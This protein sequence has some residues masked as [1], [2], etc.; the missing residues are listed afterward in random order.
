MTTLKN[1]YIGELRTEAVHAR[2]GNKIITDA[3]VD[4][5]GKGEAFSPT[6]LL[7]AALSSCVLTVMGIEA[8]RLGLDLSGMEAEVIKEMSASPR[9]IKKISIR[10]THQ[11]LQAT[12]EE[13][14]ILKQRALTCPVALSL[15]DDLEQAVIFDF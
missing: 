5:H 4:N 8:Q 13:K 10:L 7:A 6:D 14:D 11:D 15:S 1:K 2:S 3:P 12:D 9:K